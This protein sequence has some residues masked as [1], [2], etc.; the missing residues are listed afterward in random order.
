M[1][2]ISFDKKNEKLF[3]KSFH[4]YIFVDIILNISKPIKTNN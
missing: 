2:N 4:S 3:A 1:W